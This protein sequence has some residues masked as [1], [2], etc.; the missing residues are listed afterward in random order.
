MRQLRAAVATLVVVGLGASGHVVAGGAALQPVAAAV[1]VLVVAPPVWLLLR[2]RTSMPR[3]VLAIAAGQALTH[4]AL[5]AM[6]PSTGGAEVAVHVHGAGLS[7]TGS[8]AP[9]ALHL[10]SSML[11]AHLAATALAAVLLTRGADGLR[12]V[13][14]WL[15]PAVPATPVPLRTC[16]TVAEADTRGLTGRAVRPVGGRGP[17]LHAC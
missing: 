9:S 11:L 7:S 8:V 12:A 1:L 2:S 3:M 15:L 13:A 6:A 16:R 5:A 10:S 17:P 14:R 4:L